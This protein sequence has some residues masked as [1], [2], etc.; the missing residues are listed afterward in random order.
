MKRTRLYPPSVDPGFPVLPPTPERWR[1]T[2]FGDV[3]E[4]VAR[5]I[6]LDPNAK[7]RLVN[8][9]RNR[10][11]IISRAEVLG[12]EVLTKTQFEAKAG[13]FLISRRQIV[14]GACGIVPDDLDG[15]VV[16][17]EYS[18]LR[19][20]PTLLMEFLAH[21]SQ[22]PYFQRTCFHSSHGVTVEKMIFKIDEW[23]AREVDIPTL[24]EQRKIAAIL[25]AVDDVIDKTETV[26]ESLQTLKK[27]MMQEL[28]TRGLP[29]RHS[30]FMQTE[31]GEIPEGWKIG[32][33]GTF[34]ELGSGGTPSRARADFWNG[35]IPWVKTGEVNYTV[36]TDTEE[37]IT[38]A[39]LAESSARLFPKG[40]VVMALYGQGVTRGRVG[41]LGIEAATNQACLGFFPRPNLL[42]DYLYQWLTWNYDRLRNMGHEGTQKNLNAGLVRSLIIPVPPENE[43]RAIAG[44]AA[45]FDIRIAT[46]V[47]S[48]TAAH[49]AKAALLSALLTG[50][51]RVT[52]DEGAA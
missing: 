40:T 43:Q 6:E 26:I 22:T 30:R 35:K 3:L 11:G 5:P 23:L 46:E 52:P 14:H 42:P 16:S 33:L 39:G 29:G 50:E 10:G 25:L 18:T 19:T 51:V 2:T 7:Y 49:S 32:P 17:N 12:R 24:P 48:L 36:I 4:V 38:E 41:V 20:R 27:A 8:A 15:A 28:L 31:I 21:Y 1:R 44:T 34:C 9:K 13:D 37:K 47:S 45:G